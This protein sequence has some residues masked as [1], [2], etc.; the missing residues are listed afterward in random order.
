MNELLFFTILSEV[1][2][3]YPAF[4]ERA[5]GPDIPCRR[6]NTFAVLSDLSDLNAEN[7]L[8]SSPRYRELPY[9]YSRQWELGGFDPARMG[10][11]YP[12]LAVVP[13]R[14]SFPRNGSYT[15]WAVDIAVLDQ[16]AYPKECGSDYCAGRT[17][18]E[19]LR[20][21]REMLRRALEQAGRY[22]VYHNGTT[23]QFTAL[24]PSDD[25]PGG[26]WVEVDNLD[27]LMRQNFE[28][29]YI[30]DVFQDNVSGLFGS[31]T[32]SIQECHEREADWD[33]KRDKIFKLSN[34]CRGC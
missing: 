16:N 19:H 31:I 34:D 1:V 18:E 11:D 24:H 25:A 5:G 2:R 14:Y 28:A 9:F 12:I 30:R 17:Y 20:D 32:V 10:F 21:C 6:L 26:D 3:S 4:Q 29:Q 27:A 23:E 13:Q 22:I 8:K 33:I 15:D 7:L